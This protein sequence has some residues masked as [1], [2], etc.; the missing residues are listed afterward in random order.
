M[1]FIAVL[2]ALKAHFV[3]QSLSK[4]AAEISENN[5]WGVHFSTSHSN[6]AFRKK[7]KKAVNCDSLQSFP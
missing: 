6:I 7:L 5:V 2:S 3:S 4:P 1:V